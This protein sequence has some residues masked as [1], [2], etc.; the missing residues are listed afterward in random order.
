MIALDASAKHQLGRG[1]IDLSQPRRII[2]K[3]FSGIPRCLTNQRDGVN[4]HEPSP[5][6]VRSAALATSFVVGHHFA[7]AAD[8]Y[9]FTLGVASGEPTEDGFVLWTRLA[10][11]PLAL[12]K[13][14]G[15]AEPVSDYGPAPRIGC[16]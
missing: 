6:I 2:L 11:V 8:G 15:M 14:G 5:A 12:D 7:G 9:P 16:S 4:C 10:P 3:W 13:L 1:V